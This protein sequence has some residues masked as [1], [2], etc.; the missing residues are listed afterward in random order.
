MP[1][2]KKLSF[3][4]LYLLVPLPLLGFWAGGFYNFLTFFLLFTGIPLVDYLIIDA[5]NPEPNQEIK[6]K[7]DRFF[8][9]II[10]FY[11]PLQIGLLLSSLFLISHYSLTWYEWLGFTLSVGII[12][13][14]GGINLAHELMHKNNRW[15]QFLSKTLLVTVCY[16]HFFIEH[17]RGHH[18]NVGT[19]EDP[20]TARLG[21]SLYRFLPRSIGGAF[22]SAFRL[23]RCQ[24]KRKGYSIWSYHNQF[25]WIIG[26]PTLL[27]TG[28]FLYGGWPA[29]LFFFGQS[30]VA[31]TLLEIVNYIE[32][33]GLERD[34][35]AN[36]QY[37]LVSARHSWNASHWLSNA[38]LIHLQRHS[39]HHQHG[40]RPYQ[41]L[42]H[43]EESPQ[44]PSGYLGMIIL[45]LMPPLWYVVMN[46]RVIHYREAKT[47][48]N[49]AK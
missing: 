18:V 3:L 41:L 29:L 1:W 14:G 13:G 7:Q 31:F 23:E 12:T 37:E 33:Y 5:K 9:F 28:C 26:I 38:I 47:L 44:L 22:R 25:W 10:A 15:Q 45:A 32:H 36:G 46:K 17:V 4:L 42:K 2:S 40:A 30:I 48:S 43:L 21:E 27:A 39:D 34:K 49:N 19:R 6:L 16:G 11:V 35:L 24:L 20:A 8:P